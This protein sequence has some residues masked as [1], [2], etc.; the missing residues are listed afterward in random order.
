MAVTGRGRAGA[1]APVPADRGLA[2]RLPAR[3]ARVDGAEPVE[4]G[5]GDPPHP[6]ADGHPR[7]GPAARPRPRRVLLP[8]QARD[9]RR[10]ERRHPRS[11][12]ATRRPAASGC[13]SSRTTRRNSSRSP[14]SSATTTSTSSS[15][16][17]APRRWR[18]WPS[19]R[20]TA[21]CSICGCRTC[22]GFEVLETI[23]RDET[24]AAVPVVVFTGRE[25]SA[26]E[27]ARLR[28]LARSVVV[29]G[30][31]SPERLLDETSLF[32]HRVTS[33]PAA[34]EAEHARAAAPLGR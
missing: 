14:S 33:R 29:K 23:S 9:H 26:E 11:S 18:R 22:R 3:H 7:R 15:P 21:S 32:L 5:P 17:P 12:R 28:T 31:E 10:T 13:W 30:V 6:G 25:L 20:S 1:G 34:R 2:R 16:T 4:A 8:D 19:S 24:L 27:D